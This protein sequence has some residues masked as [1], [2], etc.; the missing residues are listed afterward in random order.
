MGLLDILSSIQGGGAQP[1]PTSAGEGKGMS[2]IAKAMLALLAVYALKHTRMAGSP[3]TQPSPPSGG[4]ATG[5]GGLGGG[6]GGS[7]GDVLGGMLGGGG[8][9]RSAGTA[10]GGG[11]GDLL[12]GPLG[13]ILGGAAAGTLLSGGLDGLVKRFEESGH[14]DTARS[15]VGTGASK[16]IS[17]GDLASALG[18]DTLDSLASQTGMRREELL[19]GLSRELPDFVD[20]LT[21]SGRVPSDEEAARML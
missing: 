1:A 5:G 4:S 18:A 10:G 11:L 7:L 9:G 8:A 19:S 15:W 3:P 17:Q 12:R 6:L 16:P 13:G 21:P 20:R 14:G 2:P